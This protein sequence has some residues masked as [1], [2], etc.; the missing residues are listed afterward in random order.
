[1]SESNFSSKN[2]MLFGLGLVAGWFVKKMFDSPQFEPHREKIVATTEELKLRLLESEPAERVRDIF[3]QATD[4]LLDVYL[5][6]KEKLIA[7]LSLLKVSLDE[8]EKKKYITIVT[9][10]INDLRSENKLSS[11]QLESLMTAL[12]KDFSKVTRQRRQLAIKN[13]SE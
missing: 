1:M 4:E 5:N 12:Q 8:I 10:L 6:T 3:G 11:R 7:E 13:Q 2:M 9:E